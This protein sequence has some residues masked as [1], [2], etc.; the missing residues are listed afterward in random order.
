LEASAVGTVGG[1][2]GLIWDSNCGTQNHYVAVRHPYNMLDIIAL[3]T[4]YM[5]YTY[6]ARVHVYD[7][8]IFISCQCERSTFSMGGQIVDLA[9]LLTRL[10]IMC[11]PDDLLTVWFQNCS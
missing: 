6:T 8:C 4:R 9:N 10:Y 2:F 3:Y 7:L 5:Y 11:R 1:K